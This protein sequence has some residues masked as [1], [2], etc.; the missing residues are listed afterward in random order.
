MST[1]EDLQQTLSFD[2]AVGWAEWLAKNHGA[3]SGVWL[4]LAKKSAGTSSVT[5]A[6]AIEVALCYG[7]IDGQKKSDNEHY[8]LQ[9][10]TPRQRKSI[11]SK[12]NREKALSRIARGEMQPAG[13][14]EVERAKSDGR[15]KD[16]YDSARTATVP[17]DLQAALDANGKARAFV[18]TLN[19]QNRYAVLFRIQTAKKAETRAKRIQVFVHML[20]KHETLHP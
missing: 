14:S 11:W 7:W 20:E 16:A 19:A 3:S 13:L 5:Y 6:E 18:A 4:R 15:W 8:W 10:F 17:S 9:R 12:V 1:T 2:T